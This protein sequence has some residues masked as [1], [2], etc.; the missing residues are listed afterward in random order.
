[1][2]FLDILVRPIIFV[3]FCWRQHSRDFNLEGAVEYK[4]YTRSTNKH[5]GGERRL[6]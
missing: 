5:G 3:L 6:A 1:M 4:K 2:L